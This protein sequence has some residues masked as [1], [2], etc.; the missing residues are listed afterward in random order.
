MASRDQR[1]AM[2][3]SVGGEGCRSEREAIKERAEDT[4]AG[5]REEPRSDED[6]NRR[7]ISCW[8][9]P[10]VWGGA[11]D[12]EKGRAQGRRMRWMMMAN[13]NGIGAKGALKPA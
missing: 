9:E 3:A 8:G 5:E 12:D 10:G 11:G 4:E 13:L 7:S 6:D 1:P 2:S